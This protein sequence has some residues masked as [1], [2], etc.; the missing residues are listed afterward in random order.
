MGTFK[1]RVYTKEQQKRLGV[2]E[3]GNPLKS[4]KSKKRDALLRVGSATEATGEESTS[5][6][7]EAVSIRTGEPVGRARVTS[8]MRDQPTGVKVETP[9]RDQPDGVKVETPMID[10]TVKGVNVETP[11]RQSVRDQPVGRV[12]VAPVFVGLP[13]VNMLRTQV[14][15]PT[16]KEV[17][18]SLYIYT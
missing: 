16:P 9:M 12:K 8:P 3:K 14:S 1:T 11:M 2:N 17:S 18:G 7:T 6:K 4:G 15:P 5:G 13:S 10:K